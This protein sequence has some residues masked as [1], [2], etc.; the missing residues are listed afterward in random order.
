MNLN[1]RIEEIRGDGIPG[2]NAKINQMI[3][4]LNWLMGV[5]V[6]NGRP[7]RESDQG[8]IFDLSSATA[9]GGGQ[10][11]MTDPAGNAAGWSLI[12]CLNLQTNQSFQVWIWTGQTAIGTP[13]NIPWMFDPSQVPAGWVVCSQ[14]TFWGTGSCPVQGGNFQTAHIVGSPTGSN[15]D[16]Y[17][18]TVPNPPI[19]IPANP[20]GFYLVGP[21][22]PSG[23]SLANAPCLIVNS[24]AESQDGVL[25]VTW[26]FT[27]TYDGTQ[28]F[29]VNGSTD[30]TFNASSVYVALDPT[31][32]QY[33]PG[34]LPG[35]AKGSDKWVWQYQG[36]LSTNT[37]PTIIQSFSW[38]VNIAGRLA[39]ATEW[40]AVFLTA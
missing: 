30:T 17:T 4:T 24:G 22:P 1:Q 8:P 40:G 2:Y 29:S 5:R 35:Y 9:Q 10:P 14:Q 39:N 12:T 27:I 16:V 3:R 31:G 19:I 18:C 20:P 11:W 13:A 23:S 34:G 28:V 37:N 15:P 33:D 38:S 36:A 26:T 6:T 21:S 32:W 25:T 7:V